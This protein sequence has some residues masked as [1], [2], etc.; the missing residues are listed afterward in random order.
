M[1][2]DPVFS[3]SLSLPCLSA[4]FLSGSN[5][6]PDGM[7][8]A[9]SSPPSI[10]SP[11]QL[12]PLMKVPELRLTALWQDAEASCGAN[13]TRYTPIQTGP[14]GSTIHGTHQYKQVLQ[15]VQHTVHT[16]TNRSYWEYTRR[17]TLIQTGFTGGTLDGTHQYRQVLQGVQYTVHTNTH[18]SYWAYTRRHTPIQTGFKG[19]A[20]HTIH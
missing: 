5:P 4:T 13:T 11:A 7:E 8:S 16:N 2:Q 3:F 17:H 19:C 6:P 9:P 12:F 14:T 10:Q 18:R 15:G 1:E 20:L